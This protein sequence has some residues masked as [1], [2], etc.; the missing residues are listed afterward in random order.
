M[1][2][3]LGSRVTWVS[4]WVAAKGIRALLPLVLS[5]CAVGDG[6][7]SVPTSSNVEQMMEVPVPHLVHSS[8]ATGAFFALLMAKLGTADNGAI[9]AEVG[10]Q[11]FPLIWSPG[12]ELDDTKTLVLEGGRTVAELGKEF[13]LGGGWFPSATDEQAFYVSTVQPSLE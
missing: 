4:Q 11:S 6:T 8:K 12:F 13:R 2:T 10:D 7:A 1:A 5:S 9:Q 3:A